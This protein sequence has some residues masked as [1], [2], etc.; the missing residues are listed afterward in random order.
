M[1]ICLVNGTLGP[2]DAIAAFNRWEA[3][4]LPGKRVGEKRIILVK[5]IPGE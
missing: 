1:D 3:D 2:P 4:C 5:M